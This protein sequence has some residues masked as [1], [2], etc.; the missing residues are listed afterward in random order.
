M[1][2]ADQLAYERHL[3]AL[4][5]QSDAFD[6][7]KQEGHAEGLL[8]GRAEGEYSKAISDVRKLK[9]LGAT[10]DFIIQVT[11]LSVEKIE[12]L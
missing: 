11:G 2:R 10:M 9:E 5:V 6:T 4:A 1:S 3:D 12:K 8:E 7:A